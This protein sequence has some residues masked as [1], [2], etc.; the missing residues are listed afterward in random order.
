MNV[1]KVA[2]LSDIHGNI[3]ALD[4]VLKDIDKEKVDY[5]I[6]LGDSITDFPEG[7]NLV[8]NTLK[9][10]TN[11][12][13]KGNREIIINN[14]LEDGH[15]YNQFIS[16]FLTY[17]N[18]SEENKKY[19]QKLPEQITM[20]FNSNVS[21]RCVHGS[22]ISA[23]E[24][25]YEN[26]PIN[27]K[28]LESIQEKILLCGHTHKQW[29]NKIYEKIILN[30]GYVGINFDGTKSSQYG[31]IIIQDNNIN[32]ELKNIEY[33]FNLLKKSCDFNIP[34]IRLIISGMEDGVL[35]TIKFLEEAKER[36]NVWPIPDNL[37]F[38]LFEEWC[39]RK[40]I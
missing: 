29:Y 16:T 4:E 14:G 11:L 1:I 13:I 30:P 25:I 24:H 12:S 19:I 33:N 39:R 26:D 31:L 34:W 27:I 40:I 28:I 20:T 35:Y 9:T 15:K 36:Y 8:V 2:V 6:V 3:I 32:I 5:V 38:E 7:T 22:P 10:I 21:I 23:Y 18:L 37:W 17:K